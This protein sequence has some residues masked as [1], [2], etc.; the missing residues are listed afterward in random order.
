MAYGGPQASGWI[1]ATAVDLHLSSQQ[2]HILNPLREAR[3]QT[4]NLMVPS[5]IHFCCAMMG[6]PILITIYSSSSLL[7]LVLQISEI[8]MALFLL[9]KKH[10]ILFL[11]RREK[12]ILKHQV[13]HLIIL[14]LAEDF[15]QLFW[16]K[17]RM[18]RENLQIN[19]SSITD[20]F[21]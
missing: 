13:D 6:I 9:L 14:I 2:R 20:P 16:N 3:Y 10:Y 4:H 18:F 11:W 21:I 19:F 5:Q 17:I 12:S 7:N 1:G 15:P 8:N